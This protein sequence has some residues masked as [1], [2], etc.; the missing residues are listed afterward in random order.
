MDAR[1]F[2]AVVKHHAVDGAADDIINELITSSGAPAP[3]SPEESL[4]GR[5]IS[6]FVYRGK[7]R[8]FNRAV[9]FQNLTQVD[10][11]EISGLLRD[12]AEA[13]AFHFFCV[14][15]GVGGSAPGVFEIAEVDGRKR[16]VLN[17][18]NS[19]MLHDLFSE[20]SEAERSR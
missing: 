20:V 7:L 4:I 3:P 10:R 6:E 8:K 19:E 18:E 15:D 11:D 1:E 2:V 14:L 13:T 17:P 16:R 9:W 5:S 12:C